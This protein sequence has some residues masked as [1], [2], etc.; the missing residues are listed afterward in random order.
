MAIDNAAEMKKGIANIKKV[1]DRAATGGRIGC[2][3]VGNEL[4]NEMVKELSHHG[5]G[6]LYARGGKFHQASAPGQPPAV[7][8]GDYRKSWFYR[9][10]GRGKKATLEFSTTL[11]ERFSWLEYGTSRMRARPHLRTVLNRLTYSGKI[12]DIIAEAILIEE[13]KAL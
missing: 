3:L 1:T 4:R 9:V 5:T 13:K 6:R 10:K 11:L 8:F 7:D 2:E 12:R